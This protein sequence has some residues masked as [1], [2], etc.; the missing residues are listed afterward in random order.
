MYNDM[1]R[2]LKEKHK[3]TE[4]EQDLQSLNLIYQKLLSITLLDDDDDK[5]ESGGGDDR[6]DQEKEEVLRRRFFQRYE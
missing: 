2:D 4:Y 5:K 6:S 3:M 1:L